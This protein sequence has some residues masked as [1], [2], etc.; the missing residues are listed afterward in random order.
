VEQEE[1]YWCGQAM[2]VCARKHSRRHI[3]AG[4]RLTECNRSTS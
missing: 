1:R 4:Q 2:T 3:I